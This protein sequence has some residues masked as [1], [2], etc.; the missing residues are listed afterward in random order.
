MADDDG[1]PQAPRRQFGDIAPPLGCCTED[2]L[3]GQ[4][5]DDPALSARDR[6]MV[7]GDQPDHR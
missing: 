5:W 3:F 6:G 1:K 2:V 4:E 7:T